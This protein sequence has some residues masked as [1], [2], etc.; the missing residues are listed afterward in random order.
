VIC[1]FADVAVVP[2]PFT[3]IPVTKYRPAVVLS[4]TA[5]NKDNGS[6]ILAM[7]TSARESSWPS[8]I[9]IQSHAESGLITPSI[10]RWKVFTLTNDLIARTAGTLS[11]VDT[12]A[13]K[14]A[15]RKVMG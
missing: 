2:F 6:T 14:A 8:D 12:A 3:D 1:D 4:G 13:L 10:I 5:F 9:P 11:G 15:L 7:I